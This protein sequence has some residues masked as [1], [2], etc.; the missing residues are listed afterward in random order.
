MNENCHINLLHNSSLLFIFT[1]AATANRLHETKTMRELSEKYEQLLTSEIRQLS[2]RLTLFS[3]GF[4]LPFRFISSASRAR[5]EHWNLQCTRQRLRVTFLLLRLTKI[6]L[7]LRNKHRNS[8]NEIFW[9]SRKRFFFV[10]FF[11]FD[12]AENEKLR[13]YLFFTSHF[14][15]Y[16]LST[17]KM[18]EKMFVWSGWEYF[19]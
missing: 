9:L 18:N 11:S 17:D 5:V 15:C 19:E 3:T 8:L 10:S 14:V 1:T 13:K 7:V 16:S 12:A 6:S 2:M 4:Q